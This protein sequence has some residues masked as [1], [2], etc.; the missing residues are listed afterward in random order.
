MAVGLSE[1][2]PAGQ[3]LQ[4]C[5]PDVWDTRAVS[6]Y[7]GVSW[8]WILEVTRLTF[9]A[10][11]IPHIDGLVQDCS[12]SSAFALELLQ[13]CTKPLIYIPTDLYNIGLKY[14]QQHYTQTMQFETTG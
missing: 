8:P 1:D 7:K 5:L 3:W 6:M 10:N 13:S 9:W 2:F 4:H 12:N 14:G 11:L